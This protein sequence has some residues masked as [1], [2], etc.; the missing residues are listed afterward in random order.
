MLHWR[1]YLMEAACLGMFMISACLFGVLLEHPASQIHQS[2]DDPALRRALAGTAMGLTAFGLITSPWGQRSGAHMNPAVTVTYW[3]LGK[4]A[5]RDAIGYVAGQFAGGL[6]GVFVASFLIGSALSDIPV[7]YAATVPGPGGPWIALLAEFAIAAIMMFTV[8]TASNSPALTKRTPIIAAT[9]IFLYITFE[10]P[11]SGMSMNPARTVA[12]AAWGHTW[13]ALWVY[14]LAPL[15]GML[16]A[17]AIF[18]GRVYCAKLDHSGDQ[19]CIFRC[20]F[21]EMNAR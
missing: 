17:A 16:T 21:G 18:R 6:A 13:T 3:R 12:S 14:F 7:N 20:K 2:L 19:P 11:F 8:L 10:A 15:G 9:L 1:E 5:A 4:I